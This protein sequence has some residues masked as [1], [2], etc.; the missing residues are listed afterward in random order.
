MKAIKKVLAVIVSICVVFSCAVFTTSAAV[1]G[2]G[3]IIIE[4]PSNS[5]ATVAGKTFH[6]FKVFDATVDGENIAYDWY[7]EGEVALFKEFFFNEDTSKAFCGK[8]DG[9]AQ[10]A[11][12]EIAKVTDNL[13]LS[14][15]AE[16]LYKFVKDKALPLKTATGN[17]GDTRVEFE[18]LSSGYYL[19]Y[20]NTDPT[21][22]AVR[23]AVMLYSLNQEVVITLKAN[24]PQIEK[25]V[26]ENNGVW[27]KATSCSIGE[28]VEFKITTLVPSHKMYNDYAYYIED[29]LPEGLDLK[30][31]SVKVYR[32]DTLVEAPEYYTYGGAGVNEDGIDYDFKIDFTGPITSKFEINDEIKVEYTA[33]VNDEIAPQKANTNTARLYYH[34]DPTA[35]NP[36]KGS[37]E[38]TANVYT[39]I[40]VLTK[41]SETTDGSF[42]NHTRIAGAKFKFYED[43]SEQPIKFIKKEVDGVDRYFV[44]PLE[45]LEAGSGATLFEEIEVIATGDPGE[46]DYNNYYGGNKGDI[47][48]F[49]L[50]EGTYKIV[51]TEAPSGYIRATE[52]FILTITDTVDGYG[53]ISSLTA[54][55]EHTGS[56]SMGNAGGNYKNLLTYVDIANEP[57]KKLPDTGGIGTTLFTV[58]GIVMMAGAAAFFTT[59]KRSSAV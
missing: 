55:G 48:L 59:R 19:I 40:F 54:T 56:G 2:T 57:G 26:K 33:I 12:E 13:E 35:E 17:E 41:Y 8:K 39:Y 53:A 6:L 18:E 22:S 24:R 20:D 44:A 51:E 37:S 3:K 30:E 58:L 34:N 25:Y 14:K 11:V 5:A 32:N 31:G 15:L 29:L 46:Y 4:N 27:G 43:G 38:A 45:A 52:P 49:G 50:K 10:E 47:T 9:T 21:G 42:S 28:E 1:T 36:T 16:D 23:S 7:K